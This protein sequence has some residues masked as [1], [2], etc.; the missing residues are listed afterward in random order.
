M[1]FI[2]ECLHGDTDGNAGLS[3]IYN[4]NQDE[5]VAS[6]AQRHLHLMNKSSQQVE[7][8]GAADS[9]EAQPAEHRSLSPHGT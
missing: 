4:W 7:D 8:G 6:R 1:D 3:W 5:I 9:S 2:F